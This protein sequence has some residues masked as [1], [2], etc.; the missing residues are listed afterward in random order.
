M[1]DL[2]KQV[3]EDLLKHIV[4]N[5]EKST[6]SV[7]QSQ[8]LARD[9][10]AILPA[11]DK[12][13]LLDKLNGLGQTYD[14]AKAVYLDFAKPYHA[15]KREQALSQLSQLIKQGNIEQAITIAKGAMQ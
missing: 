15:E 11:K 14:E 9:F 3:E 2:I 6:L 7:E 4:A 10:L 5:M 8:Q 1:D 12:A 13:D